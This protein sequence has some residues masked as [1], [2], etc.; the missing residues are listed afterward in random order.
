MSR[1]IADR[2]ALFMDM[3][4]LTDQMDGD[5]TSRRSIRDSMRE[6]LDISTEPFIIKRIALEMDQIDQYD[7]PPNPAKLTDARARGYVEQYGYSSWEL[8][9]L[10]PAVLDALIEGEIL[11]LLDGDLWDVGMQ[12]ESDERET[13]LE[14]A[15]SM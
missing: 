9:A 2:L 6:F 4:W 3:D 12:V 7:P 13:L 10:D 5:T 1:D 11:R 15:G 14:L 8:D